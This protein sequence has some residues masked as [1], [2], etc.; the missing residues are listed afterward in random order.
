M[1]IYLGGKE[2]SKCKITQNEYG[3]FYRGRN[4]LWAGSIE[5]FND[6]NP[7]GYKRYTNGSHKYN[8]YST[9]KLQRA[10]DFRTGAKSKSLTMDCDVKIYN[11]HSS[12][13]NW[14]TFYPV[15]NPDFRFMAVHVTGWKVGRVVRTG[16][17][18]C[19]IAWPSQNGGYGM[20][21]HITGRY[22]N[23]P[24][25]MRDFILNLD[26]FIKPKPIMKT[27]TVKSGDTLKKISK[28][29]YGDPEKYKIIYN[30]N[31][32]IIDDPGLIKPGWRLKIPE[33][34]AKD[35]KKE[36]E[37][38]ESTVK[39]QKAQLE[40][41]RNRTT[42]LEQ[43]LGDK[44]AKLTQCTKA[45]KKY[46]NELNKAL[47]DLDSTEDMLN[48]LQET[49]NGI[50]GAKEA[51]IDDLENR[52][53]MCMENKDPDISNMRW[54]QLVIELLERIKHKIKL[55]QRTDEQDEGSEDI[56]ST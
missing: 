10:L 49:H 38:L 45:K 31:L 46:Q 55:N 35:Y 37:A 50:I 53:G 54:T 30:A 23:K 11:G 14:C 18:I 47:S 19:K 16:Q 27:Y 44:N 41:L 13:G 39:Q 12:G 32:N 33:L 43:N 5:R 28:K 4:G 51:V 21:L 7:L 20:H 40:D 15:D 48:E 2:L 9:G 34:D 24:Y 42:A 26:K 1:K 22:K 3:V 29:F 52:L 36:I 25:P 56:S 8:K 17:P 6:A